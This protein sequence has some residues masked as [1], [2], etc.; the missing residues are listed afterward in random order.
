VDIELFEL[1]FCE[2][3]SIIRRKKEEVVF[4]AIKKTRRIGN[5]RYK[6]SDGVVSK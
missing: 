2:I 4:V 3:K 1:I 6:K 5:E